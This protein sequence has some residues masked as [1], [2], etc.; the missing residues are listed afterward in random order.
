MLDA[1]ARTLRL[2]RAE[3]EHLY[4]L[5]EAAPLLAGVNGVTIN[6][7]TAESLNVSAGQD[8]RFALLRAEKQK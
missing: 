4:W 1:L 8:I 3:R 6:P 5:A 2:D 7:E